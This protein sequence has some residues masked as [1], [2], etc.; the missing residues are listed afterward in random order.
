[1]DLTQHNIIHDKT[2]LVKLLLNQKQETNKLQQYIKITLHV[3]KINSL[4]N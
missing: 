1:M 4:K 3:L 2:H